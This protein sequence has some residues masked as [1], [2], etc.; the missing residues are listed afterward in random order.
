PIDRLEAGLVI[1]G[2]SQAQQSAALIE[3]AACQRERLGGMHR[4]AGERKRGVDDLRLLADRL[5]LIGGGAAGCLDQRGGASRRK[6]DGRGICGLARGE[7]HDKRAHDGGER[8]DRTGSA[9]DLPVAIGRF[10]S[11]HDCASCL[12][13]AAAVRCFITSSR[14]PSAMILP[15]SMTIRRVRI[16]SMLC[17]CVA[18]IK[19]WSGPSAVFRCSMKYSS[20]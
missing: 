20:V 15:P 5:H 2:L 1:D 12:L 3:V 11:A 9:G 8:N 19:D 4:T 18:T 16:E 10:A 17:R 13:A 14:G 7:Q 6:H